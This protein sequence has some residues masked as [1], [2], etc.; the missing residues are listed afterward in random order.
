[1]RQGASEIKS[2][3]AHQR[4]EPLPAPRYDGFPSPL[5]RQ[6][7][8]MSDGPDLLAT[9]PSSER[10][11]QSSAR[12]SRLRWLVSPERPNFLLPLT[13]FWILGLDWLLFSEEALSLGLS[14]PLTVLVWFVFGAAGTFFF[15]KRF[16]GDSSLMAMLKAVLGGV[17][18]GAPWPLMGTLVGAWIVLLAGMRSRKQAPS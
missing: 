9:T 1:M 17:V 13:G 6:R 3:V 11:D 14:I 2:R 4:I 8:S 15:Q 10:T 5:S 7:H 12:K 18:V 16:A